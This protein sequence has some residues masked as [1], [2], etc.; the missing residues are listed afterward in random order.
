MLSSLRRAAAIAVTASLAGALLVSTGGAANA[1]SSSGVSIT[2]DWYQTPDLLLGAVQSESTGTIFAIDFYN[3]RLRAITTS[4]AVTNYSI[5]GQS[6]HIAIDHSTDTV[7]TATYNNTISAIHNGVVDSRHAGSNVSGIFVDQSTGIAYFTNN[8]SQDLLK[9]DHGTI[10][11]VPLP[12]YGSSVAF[13]DGTMYVTQRGTG[14]LWVLENEVV[15]STLTID[16]G[17]APIGSSRYLDLAADS[18]SDTLW[19]TS[20]ATDE[21]V[22]ISGDTVTRHAVGDLPAQVGV[23]TTSGVAYAYNQGDQTVTPVGDTELT[24]FAAPQLSDI[25]ADP[26]S[27]AVYFVN[28]YSAKIVRVLDEKLEA[29]SLTDTWYGETFTFTAFVTNP[30]DGSASIVRQ[31]SSDSSKIDKITPTTST[32]PASFI[33]STP[34]QAYTGN[35]Y[36]FSSLASGSP[37]PT[38]SLASGV[39]PTG[40]ELDSRTGVISGIPLKGGSRT[41][42]VRATSGSTTAAQAYTISTQ[43]FTNDAPSRASVGVAYEFQF[44][45]MTAEPIIDLDSGALPAGLTLSSG[46]Y[47]YGTPTE[48]GRFTF[49]VREYIPNTYSSPKTTV[50]IVVANSVTT[51]SSGAPAT[52]DLGERY[53][54]TF[55]ANGF[56][57]PT[58][59]VS[60]GSLPAGLA[61]DKTSGVLSGIPT[62]AG[63]STFSV[64]AQNVYS[65]VR[66]S[67]TSKFTVE[68]FGAPQITSGSPTAALVG[69]PY[70]FTVK[71]SGYPAPDFG[72]IDGALPEGLSLNSSTGVISGTP[73]QRIAAPVSI[74]AF[75][76][77]GDDATEDYLV[78]AQSATSTKVTLDRKATQTYASATRVTAKAQVALVDGAYP[79]GEV[80]FSDG[81]ND[82]AS[83][84]VDD[85]GIASLVLSSGTS[86]GSHT[87]TARFVPDSNVL[88]DSS[89]T[90]KL[91]VTKAASKSSLTLSAASVKKGRTTTVTAKVTVSGVAEPTGTVAVYANGKKVA[92]GTLGSAGTV[93]I[94]LPK[95][96]STGKKKIVVKYITTTNIAASTSATKTLTVKK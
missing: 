3:S 14:T 49:T 80:V 23:D 8:L 17:S 83:V 58:F 34:T 89:S 93:K 37:L 12:G 18:V 70:S 52:G 71:A 95:F 29:F 27:G 65:G 56:P 11:S 7:F 40:L 81:E 30:A 35:R 69:S 1:A 79:E 85:T 22:S 72:I 82:I 53:S 96:T 47:L 63:A 5:S 86:A 15:T 48:A 41:V 26:S 46:G 90:A 62:Q 74:T 87:I 38:Y 68:I 25:V 39:L 20:P 24:T 94:T 13:V 50:T 76:G 21:L 9:Y 51:F 2:N 32:S 92:T 44:T 31:T 78:L 77:L 67:K 4:G 6:S 57:V 88:H 28:F 91:T 42:T 36:E 54:F 60:S 66:S 61:L 75:N 84:G 45:T 16:D 43:G 19:V 59:T 64:T 33:P 10:S 73:T 55:A